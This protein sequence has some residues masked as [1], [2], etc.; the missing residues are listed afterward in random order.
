VT[1]FDWINRW[2]EDRDLICDRIRRQRAVLKIVIKSKDETTMLRKWIH[3]H[4]NIVGPHNIILFDNMSVES[5]TA[6]IYMESRF[7]VQFARFTGYQDTLHSTSDFPELFEALR[8]SSDYYMFLD[9]DEFLYWVHPG[10]HVASDN[11]VVDLIT[12]RASSIF[13]GTWLSNVPYYDNRFYWCD[14]YGAMDPSWVWGIKWGKPIVSSKIDLVGQCRHNSELDRKFYSDCSCTNVF[15]A[16]LST[17][18]PK[19]RVAA[20]VRKLRALDIIAGDEGVS[21]ILEIDA[22]HISNELVKDYCNEVKAMANLEECLTKESDDLQ[23]GA[24]KFGR[25]GV[26]TFFEDHQRALLEEYLSDASRFISVLS[27]HETV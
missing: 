25:D 22:E 11:S 12:G 23:E 5:D 10:G 3:H 26:I 6:D 19:Q 9:T 18:S 2:S 4:L 27:R 13:P 7:L 16:H 17:L 20:N 15:V 1:G 14:R 8:A 24:I 21:A